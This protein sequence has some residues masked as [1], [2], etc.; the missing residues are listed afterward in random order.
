MAASICLIY[1]DLRVTCAWWIMSLA[2]MK[3]LFLYVSSSFVRICALPRK[4]RRRGLAGEGIRIYASLQRRR[5][6]FWCASF[7]GSCTMTFQLSTTTGFT[8]FRWGRGDDGCALSARFSAYSRHR[9]SM[10][11]DANFFFFW[12]LLY[13]HD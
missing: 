1:C 9:W 7:M 12:C 4:T 2:G 8:W 6:L 11:L 13:C 5:L 3:A 10:N